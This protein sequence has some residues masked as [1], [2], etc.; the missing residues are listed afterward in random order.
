MCIR[1]RNKRGSHISISHKEAWRISKCLIVPINNDATSIIVD[2]RPQNIIR[3][4]LTPL[5]TSFEDIQIISERIIQIIIERE[6]EQKDDSM[7]GVT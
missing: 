7:H 6:Y 5:Y 4:A 2:F 3:I 1:D